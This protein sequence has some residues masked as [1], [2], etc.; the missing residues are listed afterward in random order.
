MFCSVVFCSVVP[1]KSYRSC[2]FISGM[3]LNQVIRYIQKFIIRGDGCRFADIIIGIVIKE[4]RCFARD[5]D[6]RVYEGF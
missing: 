6:L 3:H 1:L 2:A 5:W 4:Y